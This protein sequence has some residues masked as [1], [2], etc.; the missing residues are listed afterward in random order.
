MTTHYLQIIE[1]TKQHE[2]S[3]HFNITGL[4]PL[5]NFTFTTNIKDYFNNTKA[6]DQIIFSECTFNIIEQQ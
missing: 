3:I 5:T 2:T 4:H 6:Q 1:N